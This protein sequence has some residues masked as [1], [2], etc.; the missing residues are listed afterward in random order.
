MGQ[1]RTFKTQ[2]HGFA[3]PNNIGIIGRVN[4]ILRLL[5]Y[6]GDAVGQLLHVLAHNF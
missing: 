1:I 4:D 3:G 5:R 2:T 6:V